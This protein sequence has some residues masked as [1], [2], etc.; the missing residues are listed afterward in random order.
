VRFCIHYTSIELNNVSLHF[1]QY[2]G[3]LKIG[4]STVYTK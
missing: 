4:A 3:S 1:V 2:S